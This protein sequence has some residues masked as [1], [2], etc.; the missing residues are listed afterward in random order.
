[1]RLQVIVAKAWDLVKSDRT[2]GGQVFADRHNPRGPFGFQAAHRSLQKRDM[3]CLKAQQRRFCATSNGCARQWQKESAPEKTTSDRLYH[4]TQFH[5]AYPPI[6]LPAGA[7][8]RL[9]RW[10]VRPA[11]WA[12]PR[13]VAAFGMAG[14]RVIRQRSARS[15]NSFAWRRKYSPFFAF[16]VEEAPIRAARQAA[17]SPVAAPCPFD[18]QEG[19]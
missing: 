7:S 14:G 15:R 9:R 11:S 18:R 19:A 5:P 6:D 10:T 13:R 16:M 8:P 3:A 17:R 4:R 1:M 12:V 2:T